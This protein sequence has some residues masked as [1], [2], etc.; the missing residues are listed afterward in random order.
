MGPYR[1]LQI[2]IRNVQNPSV[3]PV[4]LHHLGRNQ[5]PCPAAPSATG[6]GPALGHTPPA[7]FRA[8]GEYKSSRTLHTLTANNGRQVDYWRLDTQTEGVAQETPAG[9]AALASV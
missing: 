8:Q 3:V 6:A 2:N 1:L 7:S 4:I 5:R 9:S